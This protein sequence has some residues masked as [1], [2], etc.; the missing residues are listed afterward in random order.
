LIQLLFEAGTTTSDDNALEYIKK[1]V[2]IINACPDKD[3]F[4]TEFEINTTVSDAELENKSLK[5][6]SD[7][8]DY[9]EKQIRKKGL[10]SLK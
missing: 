5:T 6:K 8:R 1:I 3:A 10:G 4:W 7:I 9:F 2:K